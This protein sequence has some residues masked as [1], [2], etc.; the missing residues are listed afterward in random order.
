MTKR[1]SSGVKEVEL[2]LLR[3][4]VVVGAFFFF[5]GVFFFAEA[6]VGHLVFFV[7]FVD[8]PTVT[9]TFSSSVR[10][11]DSD[12]PLLSLDESSEATIFLSDDAEHM[13]I[14]REND[15]VELYSFLKQ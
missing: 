9:H 6:T 11:S 12:S 4:S 10:V 13:F 7:F 2:F 5:V 15:E 14:E 1:N 3:S 8:Q